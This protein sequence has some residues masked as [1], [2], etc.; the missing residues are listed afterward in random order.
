MRDGLPA[1]LAAAW[2]RRPGAPERAR[3]ALKTLPPGDLTAAL[4]NAGIACISLEAAGELD[5]DEER[6]AAL[7]E[8]A[9]G[10]AARALALEPALEEIGER[11][12]EKGLEALLVKGLALD[13][14]AYPHPGLRL[15][16]D[17]DILVR[18]ADLPAWGEL[19]AA[20]GYGKF[21]DVDRTWRRAGRECVDLHASSSDLVGV[22]DVPEEL[23][24]V[25]LDLAGIFSRAA[26][27]PGLA[28][29]AP[30]IE[31]HLVISAA[32]G[33][34]VHLFS[35]MIWLLDVVVL[36]GRVEGP[37]SLTELARSSGAHRALYHSLKLA[38]GAGLLEPDG[39]LLDGLR[40]RSIGR[41]EARLLARL[42]ASGLP[43]RA[44]FLLAMV[45][46]APRGYKRT[47][48]RRALMPRRRAL[49]SHGA[50][51]MRG[52]LRHLG[53][54]LSLGRLLVTG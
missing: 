28:L 24:P 19:L 43:P 39:E 3:G 47:L 4:R 35:R 44:E 30:G 41:R 49:G 22:V 34:N 2:L 23:S 46:P 38:A 26:Q 31:D 6:L 7:R 52:G 45:S 10:E 42:A 37:S 51:G 54:L 27:V 9:R 40:P 1:S 14:G 36:L 25:R 13:R 17:L 18:A 20:L 5:L 21:P 53:R 12:R 48:M 32:H 16:S 11:S 15:A 8:A 33:L 50:R 29:P